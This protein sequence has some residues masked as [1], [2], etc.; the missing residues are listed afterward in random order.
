MSELFLDA[1]IDSFKMLPFLFA[2]YLLIE[3]IETRASSRFE[4]ALSSGR[5]GVPTGALLGLF[6]QCGFSVAAARLYSSGMITAGTLAA[7]FLST[8]DE[9]IPVLLANPG[10]IGVIVRLIAAKLVIALAAGFLLDAV[11]GRLFPA[12]TR[13][14]VR[15]SGNDE[16]HVHSCGCGCEHAGSAAGIFL[17]AA[18][19]TLRILH[20]L[21][22]LMF[23]LNAAIA[24][25]GEERLAAFLM[26]ESIFQP[27]LAALFGFIP[28]CAASVILT[29]LYLD[30]A[31]S[32]GSAVAG[33]ST[34]AGLGLVVLLREHKDVRSNARFLLYLYIVSAAAGMLLQVLGVS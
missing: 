6:P 33:L 27:F 22:V 20:F 10:S 3:W 5:A 14:A 34:G 19:H 23:L 31:L 13:S 8:S 24:A 32:F 21:L 26:T 25:I 7:V 2:A 18:R 15:R 11:G 12:R 17:T 1:L 4:A 30:G 16:T 28:N 29:Q 9:A